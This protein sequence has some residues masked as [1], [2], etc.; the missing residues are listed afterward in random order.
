MKRRKPTKKETPKIQPLEAKTDNQ[1]DYIRAVAENDV[2]FCSGPA[3]CGK[4]FIAAGLAAQHLHNDNVAQIIVT[5]PLVCAGKEIGSLPG[6]I[7]DKISPYLAPMAENFKFF[8][9]RGFYGHYFNDGKIRYEPL[10]VMRGYTFDDSYMILDEAQNCTLEQIKMFI[11]RI[12][13]GSKVL[14]NGD[15]KQSDIKS[16]S[17]LQKCMDLLSDVEGVGVVK[18]TYADI[19][20]NR[21]IGRILQAL[22]E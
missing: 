14:I 16:K 2:V 6:E 12:G 18:L 8:F 21:I 7:S 10:E 1:R 5:R 3:G 22:E 13:E 9:G 11:T 15:I 20:R 17:G 19:Q 4:S